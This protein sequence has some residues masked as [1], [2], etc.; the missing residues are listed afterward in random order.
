MPHCLARLIIGAG[1]AFLAASPAR[2][3]PLD[4]L[5]A[6]W[7]I[8]PVIQE[9][10]AHAGR[11]LAV[12]EKTDP[13]PWIENGASETFAAQAVT[14]REQARALATEAAALAKNP[15]R[16]SAALQVLFRVQALD[17]ITRMLAQG[18]ARYGR[19][20]E[21]QDLAA[22]QAESGAGRDRVQAYVVNLAAQREREYLVMDQEAQ[23]CRGIVTAPAKP[24]RKK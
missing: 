3:Q 1:A 24:G 22:L 19:D 13:K 12:L 17:S 14:G 6:P 5:E 10:G 20:G 23:R 7:E 18:A 15:E 21:A 9:L 16:L 8:T 4:G 11:L 2:T